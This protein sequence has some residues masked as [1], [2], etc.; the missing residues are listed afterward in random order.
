MLRISC[1]PKSR[2]IYISTGNTEI[3]KEL[4]EE[5]IKKVISQENKFT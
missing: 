2:K 1:L 4:I 3:N 5:Y